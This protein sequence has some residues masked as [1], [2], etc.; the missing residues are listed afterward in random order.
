[1]NNYRIF[2]PVWTA[3]SSLEAALL[4]VSTK[5][6]DLLHVICTCPISVNDRRKRSPNFWTK[7]RICR[8]KMNMCWH[9]FIRHLSW[10]CACTALIDTESSTVRFLT[11]ETPRSQCHAKLVIICHLRPVLTCDASIRRLCASEDSRDMSTRIK[12]SS[13]AY[14]YVQ[15]GHRWHSKKCSLI[16]R[17]SYA[18]AGLCQHVLTWSYSDINI[19]ISIRGTQGF[20]ILMLMFMVKS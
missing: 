18:Y 20:D 14:A 1:M 6:R 2:F 9:G 12:L 17:K 16:G 7:R 11:N 19:S 10:S 13:Y 15:W 8:R 4:L 3:F 5:N